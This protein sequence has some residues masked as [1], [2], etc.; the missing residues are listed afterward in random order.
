MSENPTLRKQIVHVPQSPSSI[1]LVCCFHN[2]KTARSN[3]NHNH[4]NDD[5]SK[6]KSL[7]LDFTTDPPPALPTENPPSQVRELGVKQQH[8]YLWLANSDHLQYVHWVFVA[9]LA[10]LARSGLQRQPELG[11]DRNLLKKHQPKNTQIIFLLHFAPLQK[12]WSVCA[13]VRLRARARCSVRFQEVLAVV[14]LC[15]NCSHQTLTGV[16]VIF[17]PS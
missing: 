7:A 6:K 11:Q 5:D 12:K 9:P 1:C 14:A 17:F 15:L 4:R 3:P 8:L 13:D 10:R 2:S 16:W